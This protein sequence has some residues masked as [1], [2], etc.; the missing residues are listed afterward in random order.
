MRLFMLLFFAILIKNLQPLDESK[1]KITNQINSKLSNKITVLQKV[2]QKIGKGVKSFVR[3]LGF[4]KKPKED[5][6]VFPIKAKDTLFQHFIH[7]SEESLTI[8]C[9][10]NGQIKYVLHQVNTLLQNKKGRNLMITILK[11]LD[12][13]EKGKLL[14]EQFKIYK[15]KHLS[16]AIKEFGNTFREIDLVKFSI[17]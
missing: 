12:V 3:K 5:P 9:K 11:R 6:C 7:N 14:K 15:D 2:K 17:E 4:S 1:N 16:F 8:L 13:Y 10:T